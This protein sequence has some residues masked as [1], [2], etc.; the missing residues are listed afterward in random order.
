VNGSD[1]WASRITDEDVQDFLYARMMLWS[2]DVGDV[3]AVHRKRPIMRSLS[4]FANILSTDECRWQSSDF[5]I[6]RHAVHTCA[7]ASFVLLCRL[8]RKGIYWCGVI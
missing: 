4:R 1:G 6:D 7:P 2:S 3:C 5:L 8:K